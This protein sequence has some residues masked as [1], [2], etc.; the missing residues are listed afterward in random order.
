MFHGKNDNSS[1]QKIGVILCIG[2]MVNLQL[3]I[4]NNINCINQIRNCESY[5]QTMNDKLSQT[6]EMQK[7]MFE[8]YLKIC[9]KRDGK[10]VFCHVKIF[11]QKGKNIKVEKM[12]TYFCD[13]WRKRPKGIARLRDWSTSPQ[14]L[15]DGPKGPIGLV[16]VRLGQFLYSPLFSK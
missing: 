10:I 7:I 8:F 14:R 4:R 11:Q 5:I 2:T 6:T 1:S 12:K 13:N 3:L 16:E 9:F 15:G